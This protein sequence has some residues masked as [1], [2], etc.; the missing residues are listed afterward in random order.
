MLMNLNK[1][2]TVI[3]TDNKILDNNLVEDLK[4]KFGLKSINRV[5]LIHPPDG[6]E[7]LFNYDAG[8]RGILWSYPPYG[9]G[10]LASQLKKIDKKVEILNLQH[11]ILKN[12]RLSEKLEEF[13]FDKV[14]K[15]AVQKRINEFKP[16]FIGL[17]SMFSQSH[18]ALIQISNFVKSF[19][20]DIIIGAG[21]VHITNSV[22]DKK[23]FDKFVNEL[24]DINYFFLNDSI[25]MTELGTSFSQNITNV[26][27]KYDP[28]T[29]SYDA[30][31]ATIKKAKNQELS[32]RKL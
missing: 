25:E 24:S 15:D 4:R 2:N 17:S 30:R 13:D 28:P 16:D 8:K 21:G 23:T 26:F 3:E 32:S 19:S 31:L 7:S 22:N 27:D 18:K 29:K 1:S 6:D 14:W 12:C 9:L 20:K 10:L 11:K 5:L